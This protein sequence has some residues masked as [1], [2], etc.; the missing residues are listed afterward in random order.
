MKVHSEGCGGTINADLQCSVIYTPSSF[1]PGE[2][3]SVHNC[4]KDGR[5]SEYWVCVR[6]FQHKIVCQD[7]QIDAFHL[8]IYLDARHWGLH[9]GVC[10]DLSRNTRDSTKLLRLF[11]AK[12][13]RAGPMDQAKLYAYAVERDLPRITRR[14]PA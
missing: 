14:V 11:M 5:P 7:S 10:G 9:T 3:F 4:C 6:M 13:L 2:P 1:N 8:F 12:Q